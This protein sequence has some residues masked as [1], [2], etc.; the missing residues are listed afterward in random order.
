GAWIGRQSLRS[1]QTTPAI[2]SPKNRSES[3]TR[4]GKSNESK[5]ENGRG[6]L[7]ARRQ[8]RRRLP[9]PVEAPRRAAEVD[10]HEDERDHAE[11]DQG[12]D[13]VLPPALAREPHT[14]GGARARVEKGPDRR[15]EEQHAGHQD[16]A[17]ES[18]AHR[19]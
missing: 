12:E 6:T 3:R 10:A 4:R 5:R 16:A 15:D 18:A 19:E 13:R 11:R 17:D 14:L 1:S 8:L 9:R 2:T 7:E